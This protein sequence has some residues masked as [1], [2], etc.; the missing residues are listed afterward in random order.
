MPAIV[1]CFKKLNVYFLILIKT[2]VKQRLSLSEGIVDNKGKDGLKGGSA[3]VTATG[4]QCTV[5]QS[6]CLTKQ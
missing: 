3:F 2:G 4:V 5:D 6:A 1:F